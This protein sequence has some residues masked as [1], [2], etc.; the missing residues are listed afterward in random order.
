ME[1]LWL[2]CCAQPDGHPSKEIL[3]KQV[4]QLRQDLKTNALKYQA[5]LSAQSAAMNQ[6]GPHTAPAISGGGAAATTASAAVSPGGARASTAQSVAPTQAL[7][8]THPAHPSVHAMRQQM[9]PPQEL[10]TIEQG[11]QR[12]YSA[13]MASTIQS[14]GKDPTTVQEQQ[15]LF[16]QCV[17]VIAQICNRYALQDPLAYEKAYSKSSLVPTT[18]YRKQYNIYLRY[19]QVP[20]AQRPLITKVFGRSYLRCIFPPI[21]E[22]FG[23]QQPQ[24]QAILG[25]LQIFRNDLYSP[26][27]NIWAPPTYGGTTAV[28]A[29]SRPGAVAGQA[30]P[31]PASPGYAAAT[32]VSAQQVDKTAAGPGVQLSAVQPHRRE[33]VER[34]Q[35]GFAAHPAKRANDASTAATRADK[36]ACEVETTSSPQRPLSARQ[37]VQTLMA[38][39][40]SQGLQASVAGGAQVFAGAALT[41]EVKTEIVEASP[42]RPARVVVVPPEERWMNQPDPPLYTKED[43]GFPS[44][45]GRDS[46]ARTEEA[47]KEIQFAVLCNNPST[48]QSNGEAGPTDR[49]LHTLVGIKNLFGRALPKMPKEYIARTVFDWKH[50]TLAL[51]KRN[52]VIGGVC[53]RPFDECGFLEIVFCAVASDEQVKGYGTYLMNNLKVY[54]VKNGCYNFFTYADND[55]IGYFRKQGFT[56]QITLPK[57]SIHGYIKDYDGGTQMQC[58]LHPGVD[59]LRLPQMIAEQ[60]NAIVKAVQARTTTDKTLPGLTVFS[61]G[62]TFIPIEEIAGVKEAGWQP[63]D[64]APKPTAARLGKQE[65]PLSTVLRGLLRELKQHPSAWPFHEPVV[66]AEA[67]EYYNIIKKPVDLKMIAL[68]IKD[69]AYGSVDDLEVDVNQMLDNCRTYN[70][71]GTPY[72]DAA[73]DLQRYFRGLLDNLRE[74]RSS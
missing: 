40:K 61:K 13:A 24:N 54:A 49:E 64:S 3:Y 16:Q 46:R 42:R 62:A 39:I 7:R 9:I 30:A 20:D 37:K 38:L 43:L 69:K 17:H 8:A 36:T 44:Q 23:K 51:L 28:A 53:F 5:V 19:R 32:A 29:A 71:H 1:R 4:S 59:Y 73:E 41:P 34:A 55:A 65:K 67:P 33:S 25:A 2:T 50:R 10:P 12:F 74:G 22:Y 11:L 47:A 60:R 70:A 68:R 31:P 27:S 21:W 6:E 52:A 18:D 48:K 57:R 56:K 45:M 72:F 63:S 15:K 66:A 26:Q 58:V 14:H 35:A